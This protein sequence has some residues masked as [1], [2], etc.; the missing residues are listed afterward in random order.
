MN[1]EQE[2]LLDEAILRILDENDQRFGLGANALSHLVGRFGF[3][4]DKDAIVRRMEYMADT[5]IGYVRQVDKGNFNT[6]ARTWR[7]TAKGTNHL[8]EQGV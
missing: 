1:A 8:R 2:Q 4:V 3:T 5:D 7:I 6:A